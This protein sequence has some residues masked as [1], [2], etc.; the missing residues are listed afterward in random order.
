MGYCCSRLAV[1]DG[2]PKSPKATNCEQKKEEKTSLTVIMT[3]V[4]EDEKQETEQQKIESIEDV[5]TSEDVKTTI[6]G[7]QESFKVAKE[8]KNEK[9]KE[10]KEEEESILTTIQETDEKEI[11]QQESSTTSQEQAYGPLEQV[12]THYKPPK[13][14]Y[15]CNNYNQKEIKQQEEM[16]QKPVCTCSYCQNFRVEIEADTFC[17]CVEKIFPQDKDISSKM[18]AWFVDQ[19]NNMLQ[20][21]VCGAFHKICAD[22]AKHTETFH[23]SNKQVRSALVTHIYQ[24]ISHA[25]QLKPHLLFELKNSV[26]LCCSVNESISVKR[27]PKL[28]IWLRRQV[29]HARNVFL[30]FLKELKKELNV[31]KVKII[32]VSRKN[33]TDEIFNIYCEEKWEN[34]SKMNQTFLI[35]ESNEQ[36]QSIFSFL[37]QCSTV[38]ILSLQNGFQSNFFLSHEEMFC[39]QQEK[40]KS[41][42]SIS[43]KILLGEK[44]P[45][46]KIQF[47]HHA[48]MQKLMFTSQLFLTTLHFYKVLRLLK[49]DSYFTNPQISCPICF[50]FQTDIDR[51]LLSDL[52][53][54]SL[55]NNTMI[56][57]GSLKNEN[58]FYLL[59]GLNDEVNKTSV[60]MHST[61]KKLFWMFYFEAAYPLL[62]I[63]Y[64]KDECGFISKRLHGNFLNILLQTNLLSYENLMTVAMRMA[65]IGAFLHSKKMCTLHLH[66][67]NIFC[68]TSSLNNE[69]FS[70]DFR[71]FLWT[72]CQAEGRDEHLPIHRQASPEQQS[73]SSS[74][75][76]FSIDVYEYGCLLIELFTQG[77]LS[78]WKRH[79]KIPLRY[80]NVFPPQLEKMTNLKMKQIA[81]LCLA[82]NPADRPSMQNVYSYIKGDMSF[83]EF[84]CVEIS[85]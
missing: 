28:A 4:R 14:F 43:L 40:L 53:I 25:V 19:V 21:N 12:T 54:E 5:K 58:F 50:R 62:G 63:V 73:S 42:L 11:F 64:Q 61:L 81:K 55:P 37:N 83:S 47:Y 36:L 1:T 79:Q 80:K 85:N 45:S 68:A 30:D 6:T 69:D 75:L 72:S 9:Q 39:N 22:K 70:H 17:D 60:E 33:L 46:K 3:H 56:Q 15:E 57:C 44:K 41:A 13:F 32:V 35:F 18:M 51:K 84:D 26:T 67:K 78:A 77:H 74:H 66:S 82:W 7:V 10:D 27:E 31:M 49:Y 20:R 38:Q 65:E 16:D 23:N 71:P 29:R 76:Q 24:M 52:Q 8:N 2:M 34:L 59:I 48:H